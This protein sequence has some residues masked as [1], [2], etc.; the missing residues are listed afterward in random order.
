MDTTGE[1]ITMKNI[2]FTLVASVLL[3]ACATGTKVAPLYYWGNFQNLQY[4]SF[5]DTQSVQDQITKMQQY[6]SEAQAKSLKPAP[7][8]YAHLG[9]LYAKTGQAGEAQ[10]YLELEKN[11]Y[12]ESAKYVDFVIKNMMRG[13]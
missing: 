11:T 2:I 7:G 3:T 10:K 9:M 6:F 8:S 5:D 4:Q 1:L 12:P 13:K